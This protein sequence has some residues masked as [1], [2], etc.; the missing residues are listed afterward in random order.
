MNGI[1]ILINVLGALFEI[2]LILFLCSFLLERKALNMGV[3]Y[4]I[5]FISL[6]LLVIS[7]ELTKGLSFGPGMAFL[8]SYLLIYTYETKLVIKLVL[9]LIT[10]SIFLISEMMTGMLLVST[11]QLS[12]E[13]IRNNMFIYLCAVVFS[14]FL[15]Y[16]I[17]LMIKEK[18]AMNKLQ[19][20]KF[21]SYTLI[22]PLSSAFTIYLLFLLTYDIK[23]NLVFI[24]ELAVTLLILANISTLYIIDR[25][26]EYE[27]NKEKLQF[28]Q[29]QFQVQEEHYKEQEQRQ[30]EINEFYHNM[31]NYLLAVEG[32][33]DDEKYNEAKEKIKQANDSL[34]S[35][36]HSRIKTGNT[37]LDALLNAKMIKIQK[38]NIKFDYSVRIPHILSIDYID[39]CII[40][41]NALDNSI[42]ACEK[43][44]IGIKKISLTCVQTGNYISIIIMNTTEKNV[45]IGKIHDCVTTKPDN[46]FHGYGLQSIR[47]I[48]ERN[49]GNVIIEQQ[50]NTFKLKIILYNEVT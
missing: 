20:P 4:A 48:A 17:I 42:E 39:L 25:L 7:G 45:G 46:G 35:E 14:K 10:F 18:V 12:I 50:N 27:N 28:M 49:K 21:A 6:I 9:T 19:K 22:M 5:Y 33:I 8:A 3:K 11:T 29:K 31:K 44:V 15:V 38:G 32:Y 13:H 47:H 1:K 23:S 16:F 37:C 26:L 40:I 34:Y 43:I 41:G 24:V 2:Y 36:S 30:Y